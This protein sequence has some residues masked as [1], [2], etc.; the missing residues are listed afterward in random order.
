MRYRPAGLEGW[1]LTL[2]FS[3][4]TRMILGMRPGAPLARAVVSLAV[5]RVV[6]FGPSLCACSLVAHATDSRCFR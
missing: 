3:P 2:Y 6:G 4:P 5:W 1:G